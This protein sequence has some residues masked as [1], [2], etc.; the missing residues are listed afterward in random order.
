MKTHRL[1]FGKLA[2]RLDKQ[3]SIIDRSLNPLPAVQVLSVCSRISDIRSRS[4]KWLS[5]DQNSLARQ[6]TPV[7]Q[8]I[9]SVPH[10]QRDK[11]RAATKGYNKAVDKS[12]L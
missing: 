9:K 12:V 2:T 6:N 8:A 11:F 7:L 10:S 5:L 1:I 4:S 3:E